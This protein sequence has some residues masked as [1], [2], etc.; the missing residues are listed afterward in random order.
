MFEEVTRRKAKARIALT[1]VSGSGKT[2]SALLLAYGLTG[3]WSKV[4]LIDT[5]HERARF[6]AERE[7]FGTGK[8]LYAPMYPPYSPEKYIQAVQEGAQVVGNDGVVIVDSFSH[9]WS[10][11]A[12][13]WTSRTK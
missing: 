9:A 10:S 12:E 3:D 5:E 6:Y 11:E 13:C 8:F 4:A 2:L 7:D 1:G